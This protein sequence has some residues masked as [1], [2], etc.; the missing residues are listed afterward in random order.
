LVATQEAKYPRC[1]KLDKWEEDPDSWP[2]LT[3]EEKEALNKCV[4][5]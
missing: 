1:G 3:E 2:E 5:M 4:I